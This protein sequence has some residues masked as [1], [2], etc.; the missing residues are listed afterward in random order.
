VNDDSLHI[1]HP[2][3]DGEGVIL[4]IPDITYLDTQA[5][6]VDIGLTIGDLHRL[7]DFLN[8]NYGPAQDSVPDPPTG[9]PGTEARH[10][11]VQ[12]YVEGYERDHDEW[13]PM[14]FPEGSLGAAEA[15]RTGWESR[16]PG[17]PTRIVREVTTWTIEDK[18]APTPE[19][20][21]R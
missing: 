7:R 9:A 15:E 14:G 10:P 3:P 19:E 17:K 12:W 1:T 21:P 11:R 13:N 8:Q 18:P 2:G 16:L 4:H 6:S 20:R 5:W